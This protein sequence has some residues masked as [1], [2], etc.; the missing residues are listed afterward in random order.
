[1]RYIPQKGETCYIS[2]NGKL[3]LVFVIDLLFRDGGREFDAMLYILHTP[4]AIPPV[5][6]RSECIDFIK[7]DKVQNNAQ[8]NSEAI[9]NNLPQRKPDKDFAV[10]VEERADSIV[11]ITRY[12]NFEDYL[13]WKE[14]LS[15]CG[16]S[17]ELQNTLFKL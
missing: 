7:A 5:C 1:M 6:V 10:E 8:V 2:T 14:K 15:D 17:Y 12:K 9:H 13:K 3:H 4:F 11:T 16:T